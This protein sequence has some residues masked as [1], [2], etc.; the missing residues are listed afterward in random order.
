MI[1]RVVLV[2]GMILHP[3]AAQAAACKLEQATFRPRFPAEH[4][5]MRSSRDGDHL[6]FEITVRRTGETFPFRVHGE[7]P[8]GEGMISSVP[9]GAGKDAGAVPDFDVHA[10]KGVPE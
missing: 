5:V 6:R 4:F 1:K 10:L 9:N 8:T 3:L 7:G 2:G